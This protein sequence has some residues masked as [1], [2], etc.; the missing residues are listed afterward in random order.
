M[1]WILI[2]GAISCCIAF[3]VAYD[4]TNSKRTD[5][6]LSV[7][8]TIML[9]IAITGVANSCMFIIA[10]AKAME[11]TV[12]TEEDYKK[13]EEIE[14]TAL[15]DN[16]ETHGKMKGNFFFQTGKI[17]EDLYYVY[18]IDGKIEKIAAEYITVKETSRK[19]AYLCTYRARVKVKCPLN[20][21][22]MI[23]RPDIEVRDEKKVLEVP[24]GTID[25]TTIIDLE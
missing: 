21:F 22:W 18:M 15:K 2:G 4:L 1:I 11:K 19:K 23:Y 20:I 6:A 10:D 5:V 8:F 12:I 7:V 25:Q 24:I 14:I 13:I 9:T 16:Y 17:D 3:D